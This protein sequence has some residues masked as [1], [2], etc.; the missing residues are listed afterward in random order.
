MSVARVQPGEIKWTNVLEPRRGS[1][2]GKIKV[3]KLPLLGE[4]VPNF[5]GRRIEENTML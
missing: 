4:L 2:K 5:F 1:T 3:G